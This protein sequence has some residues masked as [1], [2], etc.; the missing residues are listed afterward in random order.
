MYMQKYPSQ[1]MPVYRNLT[2]NIHPIIP[3]R[4]SERTALRT[5]ADARPLPS[6]ERLLALAVET[7]GREIT[8]R[9]DRRGTEVIGTRR[10]DYWHALSGSDVA[11]LALDACG[12][13][14]LMFM[15]RHR[16]HGVVATFGAPLPSVRRR[17]V[18][19]IGGMGRGGTIGIDGS[20][21][22]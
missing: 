2:H 12:R 10:C 1:H 19:F 11:I 3:R 18:I 16:G 20:D 21:R 7:I 13:L 9:A 14:L 17:A 4:S 5:G 22:R 8:L 15:F 6:L